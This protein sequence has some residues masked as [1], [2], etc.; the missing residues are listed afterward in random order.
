MT[1]EKVDAA[2]ATQSIHAGHQDIGGA[3]ITPIFQSANFLQKDVEHY[4]DVKYLR[5]SNTPQHNILHKRL[6]ALDEGERAFTFASGMAAVSNALLA[7]LSAGD[8]ALIQNPCYGGTTQLVPDLNRF[9]IETTFINALD[10]S[11]YKDALKPNTKVIYV[12]SISNP[13][14][15]VADLK[16]AVSFAKAHDL[17]SIIDNTFLSPAG[18][19]PLPFGF[20]L[21]VHSAT[22]FM[23]GHSDIVAGVVCGHESVMR[24]I[25]HLASHLGG[26][27]DSHAAFLLERGLKTLNLRF[28]TQCQN[29]AQIAR[30]LNE[31]KQVTH[32][33]FPGIP[34]HPGHTRAKDWFEDFGAVMSFE[35]KVPDVHKKLRYFVHAASLGSVESLVVKPSESTHLG[36]DPNERRA[37]GIADDLIRL[38]IGVEDVQDLID[39]LAQALG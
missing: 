34:T 24:P 25:E 14:L 38:S 35:S 17:I 18:F 36:V 31:H 8:H 37:S 27:L 22:K 29:A 30:F 32:V 33:N 2:L 26:S 21:V 15:G 9:G 6:A 7:H 16:G 4:S 19:K 1:K 20:D 28:K 5:L 3:V 39:D 10:S 13:L 11:S 12:E 23:N